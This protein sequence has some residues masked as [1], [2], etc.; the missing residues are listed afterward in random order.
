MQPVNAKYPS[1]VRLVSLCL[2]LLVITGTHVIRAQTA[3]AGFR[4]HVC[5][6][7]G[8]AIAGARVKFQDESQASH[9]TTSEDG[10]FGF[11][12]PGRAGTLTIDA[13]GFAV[14][15]QRLTEAALQLNLQ[16]VLKPDSIREQ[17]T[18]TAT[19]TETPLRSTAASARLLSSAELSTTA[20]LTIDDAL[21]QVPGFQLFRRSGSRTAN[22]TSQGASLRGVGASGASRALVLADGLPF[23]DPFGGWIYWDRMPRAAVDQLEVVRGGASDLYGNSAMGGV[24]NIITRSREVPA[25]SLDLSYGNQNS[26]SASIYGGTRFKK[27]ST[28][29]AGELFH[30]NGYI[31]VGKTDRGIVDTP[32]SSRHRSLYLDLGYEPS[33]TVRLFVKPSYFAESRANGTSLQTNRTHVGEIDGGANFNPVRVGEI[34]LRG[35]LSRQTYDQ[36]FSAIATHRNTETLT[37]VQRVPAQSAGLMFQWSR[38]IGNHQNLVG[39]LEAREVRGASD[40]IVYDRGQAASLVGAGGRQRSYALFFTDSLHLNSRLSVSAGARLDLFRNLDGLIVSRAISPGAPESV[41]QFANV[42]EL[43]FSPHL[44]ILYNANPTLSFFGSFYGAFRAPTLNELYRSFRVG[45]V[46]TLANEN[47]KRERARGGEA[48]ARL[49]LWEDRFDLRAGFFAVTVSDPIANLTLANSPALITRLRQNLGRTRSLGLEIDSNLR[50]KR[51]LN[52]NVG[53]LLSN[54]RVVSFP[55]N[56]LLEG[57]VIPQ[58]PRTSITF[59]I[60]YASPKSYKF[61]LQGRASGTQFEDDQN[62]LRL[63]GFFTLDGYVARNLNRRLEIFVAGENILNSRYQVGRTP[64][65]TVGPSI[66]F[67][68]GVKV[69]Y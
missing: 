65:V 16:I 52:I 64:V 24:I 32:V 39:G 8:A 60:S 67:R 27:F 55:A 40:E 66:L 50:L 34:S 3:S 10:N 4:G 13:P 2:V 25:L 44:S 23:A 46:I 6:E 5:D 1:R 37:R 48:G 19:R 43:S 59:Q 62:L 12:R 14:F 56:T 31:N 57:L 68:A 45:N 54:A 17:V 61:G 63:P 30:T 18:V 51:S 33:E 58:T 15:S 21:R 69:K 53:Y 7:S 11:E 38:S 35:Y 49:S 47:L 42:S 28:T 36:M 41:T 22:P 26:P 9:T 29:L 20:A